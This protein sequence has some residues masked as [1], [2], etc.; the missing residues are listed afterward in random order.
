MMNHDADTVQT[1]WKGRRLSYS[2]VVPSR[3]LFVNNSTDH[4]SQYLGGGLKSSLSLIAGLAIQYLPCYWKS[5]NVFV[6]EPS[7]RS[8]ITFLWVPA[9]PDS[10]VFDQSFSSSFAWYQVES[11]IAWKM[12]LLDVRGTV[13]GTACSIQSP[14]NYRP[15][16]SDELAPR[17]Q[18]SP[19]PSKPSVDYN[20]FGSSVLKDFLV[21]LPDAFELIH[22][23]GTRAHGG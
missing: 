9:L 16:T 23:T 17:Y 10:G 18:H 11:H 22:H 1:L 2:N 5:F 4:I 8:C 15:H 14:F 12:T 19:S 3:L 6:L 21:I 20:A 13:H 7:S